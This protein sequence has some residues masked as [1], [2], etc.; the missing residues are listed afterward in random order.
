M[1]QAFIVQ[2]F[3]YWGRGPTLKDAAKNCFCAGA[4]RLDKVSAQFILGDDM[5]EIVNSGMNIRHS[6]EATVYQIGSGFTLGSLLR[7]KD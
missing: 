1:K 6:Q 4:S 7:L 3:G 5:P 2:T